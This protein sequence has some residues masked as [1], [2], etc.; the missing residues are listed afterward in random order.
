MIELLRW[1]GRIAALPGLAGA[2]Y[3]AAARR[4]SDFGHVAAMP[5]CRA[6]A[7]GHRGAARSDAAALAG[8]G[9]R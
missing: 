2:A 3:V 8:R 4:V 6:V 7:G 9:R 5:L 1:P